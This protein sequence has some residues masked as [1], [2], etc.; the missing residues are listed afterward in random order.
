MPV[1]YPPVYRTNVSFLCREV[2]GQLDCQIWGVPQTAA[3]AWTV[4]EYPSSEMLNLASSW[5]TTPAASSA[6]VTADFTDGA[7]YPTGGFASVNVTLASLL[8]I[9]TGAVY[10]LDGSAASATELDLAW[11]LGAAG[12]STLLVMGL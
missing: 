9:Q 8:P 2:L 1:L 3:C 4:G 12:L 10:S 7:A 11:T 6:T 5:I